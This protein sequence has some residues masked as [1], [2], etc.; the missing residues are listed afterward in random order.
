MSLAFLCRHRKAVCTAAAA[1]S[2]CLVGSAL[3]L[4]RD[5]LPQKETAAEEVLYSLLLPATHG[6]EMH[7][8]YNAADFSDPDTY[9]AHGGGVGDFHY[10]NSREAVEDAIGKGFR[11]IELDLLATTDG[12]L[13]AGHSWKN[14]KKTCGCADADNTPLTY[15]EFLELRTQSPR[16]HPIEEAEI[17]A[18]MQQHPQLVLVVDKLTDY[19][20]LLQKLPFPDRMIVEVFSVRQYVQ[21]LRAGV[22]YPAYSVWD[23]RDFQTAARLRFP[24]ITLNAEAFYSDAAA[25]K[26][27]QQLHQS[28]VTVLMYYTHTGLG[29]SPDFLKEHAGKTFSKVYTDT[30]SPADLPALQGEG[31]RP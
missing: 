29:D 30:W 12:H 14:L 21:A 25:V 23:Q 1:L 16:F 7:R 17:A 31:S 27:L 13:V 28:G 24:I 10:T 5:R 19:T 26:H 20:T 15:Q 8:F 3:W 9:I 18:A 2:L 4:K 11:F 22:H 6:S